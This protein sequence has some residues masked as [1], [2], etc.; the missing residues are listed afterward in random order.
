LHAV[1]DQRTPS[2]AKPAICLALL[3]LGVGA[4][5]CGSSHGV[6]RGTSAKASSAPAPATSTAPGLI[7]PVSQRAPEVPLPQGAGARRT[8]ATVGNQKISAA[9]VE[10]FM[11]VKRSGAP[12]PDPP[13][14][15]ACIA[16]LKAGKP[17]LG[18]AVLH[19]SEA[20][21][22]QIC[23]VR[24]QD[25]VSN[26]LARAIHNRWLLGEAAEEGI[27][28]SDREVQ[29]EIAASKRAFHSNAKFEAYL[30]TT[31]QSLGEVELEGRLNLLFERIFKRIESK[32]HSPGRA[33]VAAY[34]AAHPQQ[35]TIP[36]GRDV[37]IV[38]TS[39]AASAARVMQELRSGKSFAAA[40]LEL[41]AIGQ[42]VKTKNG[43]VR[44]LIRENYQEPALRNA[45]FSTQPGRLTGPIQVIAAHRTIASETNSG[46]FIFEVRRIV[47]A[48]ETPLAQLRGALTQELVEQRKKQA[49]ASFTRAFK[50]R[51]AAR[52]D[53]RP[54]YVVTAFCSRF[55]QSK[56]EVAAEDPYSL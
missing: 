49:V 30:K 27:K 34:Y 1:P 36:E 22:T 40:A 13:S 6:Q 42:P 20:Q 55:K 11:Q 48:H 56:A 15:K 39:T 46:Y 26:A 35:F 21:L 33:E 24:F 16:G 3:A 45:I 8:I 29:A 32:E 10:R 19:Q 25:Q 5:G 7:Q 14:Y 31:G 51:W 44:D 23:K 4:L 52:T 41:S 2:H 12:V 50:H 47:P 28:V 37:R 17:Q 54:G 43:E 53:C 9:E 18:E 38:R